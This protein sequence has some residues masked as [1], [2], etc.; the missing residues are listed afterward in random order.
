MAHHTS[1]PT[2][3][4]IDKSC[5]TLCVD[6]DIWTPD[7]TVDEVLVAKLL[8]TRFQLLDGSIGERCPGV[9]FVVPGNH[10]PQANKSFPRT[11][12]KFGSHG[13]LL[14]DLMRMFS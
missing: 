12:Q 11:V 1:F 5:A 10:D 2:P 7:I 8:Q 3:L 9:I 13:D 6:E 14:H 4:K